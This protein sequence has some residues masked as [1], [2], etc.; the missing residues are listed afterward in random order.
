[1]YTILF[2]DFLT[3]N[4]TITAQFSAKLCWFF[5]MSK[6]ISRHVS[7]CCPAMT[8]HVI[9][10]GPDDRIWQNVG[11]TFPTFSRKVGTC[12][13]NMSFGGFWWHNTTSTFPTK[14]T[15]IMSTM[16]MSYNCSS[17]ISMHSNEGSWDKS[18]SV[19]WGGAYNASMH[20]DD[21]VWGMEDV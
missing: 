18:M 14:K 17:E 9:W 3:P 10:R 5:F 1:M 11:P 15:T 19:D 2:S 4:H 20:Q 12:P 16:D 8:C 21:H 13:D 6:R 7:L